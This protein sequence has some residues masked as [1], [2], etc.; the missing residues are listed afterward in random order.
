MSQ[1]GEVPSAARQRGRVAALATVAFAVVYGIGGATVAY[2]FSSDPLGPRAIPVLLALA[3]GVFGLWYFL[4]PGESE[5][6]AGQGALP[7]QLVF[8]A[9]FA[10]SAGGLDLI[11]YPFAAAILAATVAFLF[12]APAPSAIGIGLALALVSHSLFVC[13]LGTFLP[14]GRLIAPLVPAA[15]KFCG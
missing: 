15:L 10:V 9:V 13:G 2:S 4:A 5:S 3:L 6:F 7:K 11:G 12:G 14:V 8:A 1:P